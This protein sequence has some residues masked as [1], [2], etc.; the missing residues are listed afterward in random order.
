MSRAVERPRQRQSPNTRPAK[1]AARVSGV[2]ERPAQSTQASRCPEKV[3]TPPPPTFFWKV[4]AVTVHTKSP[5]VLTR[6]RLAAARARRGRSTY[7]TS[8]HTASGSA[9]ST[10]RRARGASRQRSSAMSASA[11]GTAVSAMKVWL[12][13][14]RP[15]STTASRTRAARDS[16]GA[17]STASTP[18]QRARARAYTSTRVA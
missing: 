10:K 1:A 9:A 6:T 7:G 15:S 18:T 3:P 17:H 14:A 11:A 13:P 2:S 8:E 4:R 16:D 5:K 12:H